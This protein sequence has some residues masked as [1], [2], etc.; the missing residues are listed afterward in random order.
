MRNPPILLC[1]SDALTQFFLADEVRPLRELKSKYGIQPAIVQEVDNELRWMRRFK[2]RFVQQLDKALKAATL[3]VLDGA[4]F[5][6]H[7]SVAP[8]GASWASFQSLGSRYNGYVD[9]GEAYTFA[10]AVTLGFPAL[11]NDFSAIRVLE[12]KMQALPTP[13]LR[14]FDLFAFCYHNNILSPNECETVRSSLLKEL[15]GLPKAFQNTSFENGVKSFNTRLQNGAPGMSASIGDYKS[16]LT[17]A[18]LV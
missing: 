8:V 9:L 12:G 6:S 4:E 1:D 10:A 11:S 17:I 3:K 13:V 18:K 14:S 2:D 5:H 15:E 7:L 16:T